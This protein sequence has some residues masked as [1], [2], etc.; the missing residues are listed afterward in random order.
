MAGGAIE[1]LPAPPAV[2]AAMDVRPP[3]RVVGRSIPSSRLTRVEPGMRH[4]VAG[5]PRPLDRPSPPIAIGA[6][7]EQTLL[8]TDEHHAMPFE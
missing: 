5:D 4:L 6:K 7:A 2:V 1:G 3:D 8:S